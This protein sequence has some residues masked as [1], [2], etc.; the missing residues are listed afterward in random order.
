MATRIPLPDPIEE[1]MAQ[2]AARLAEDLYGVGPD[3]RVN[4]LRRTI[5]KD[6]AP[7]FNPISGLEQW[8]DKETK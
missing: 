3:A 6:D 4:E 7:P 2:M 8:L 1:A 5:L